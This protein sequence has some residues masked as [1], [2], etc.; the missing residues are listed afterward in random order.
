[1]CNRSATSQKISNVLRT[2]KILQKCWPT[3]LEGTQRIF[4]SQLVSINKTMTFKVHASFSLPLQTT[5]YGLLRSDV[6]HLFITEQL[7]ASIRGGGDP[8]RKASTKSAC[9]QLLIACDSETRSCFP[10]A[11]YYW[12]AA[13]TTPFFLSVKLCGAKGPVR[14]WTWQDRLQQTGL[15]PVWEPRQTGAKRWGRGVG[16]VEAKPAILLLNATLEYKH[17]RGCL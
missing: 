2:L 4:P 3:F 6:S 11:L 14:K 15:T 10:R 8:V 5:A 16:G 12:P 1:M 9:Q 13:A 7:E 17:G